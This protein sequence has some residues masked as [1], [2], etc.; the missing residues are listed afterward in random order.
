MVV[1]ILHV[2]RVVGRR[3]GS[4]VSYR[5]FWEIHLLWGPGVIWAL[6]ARVS[7]VTVWS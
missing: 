1:P 7:A 3:E 4:V 2:I 5:V 6:A